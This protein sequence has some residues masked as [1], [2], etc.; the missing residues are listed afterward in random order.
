LLIQL[1]RHVS[2]EIVPDWA[3]LLIE[4][5]VILLCCP[6]LPIG[7]M[8]DMLVHPVYQAIEEAEFDK[9]LNT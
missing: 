3:A 8:Q 7:G 6:L 2:E 1:A 4:D 5:F 9:E